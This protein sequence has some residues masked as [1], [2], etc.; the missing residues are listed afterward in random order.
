MS[1]KLRFSFFTTA[2]LVSSSCLAL[3]PSKIANAEILSPKSSWSFSETD[4]MCSISSDYFE[5]DIALKFIGYDGFIENFQVSLPNS[6]ALK[7]ISSYD[8]K[9]VPGYPKKSLEGSIIA[10]QVVFNVKNDEQ[11]SK[12]LKLSG[13]LY[14]TA[15]EE[16]YTLSLSGIR[17]GMNK[18]NTC[19][20][21]VNVALSDN[22]AKKVSTLP[23]ANDEIEFFPLK[24]KS[25]GKA[26][27]EK[28]VSIMVLKEAMKQPQEI[29][30]I[31]KPKAEKPIAVESVDEKTARGKVEVIDVAETPVEEVVEKVEVDEVALNDEVSKPVSLLSGK[32]KKIEQDPALKGNMGSVQTKIEVSKPKVFV[33]KES[34]VNENMYSELNEA[35]KIAARRIENLNQEI[36]EQ[37]LDAQKKLDQKRIELDNLK[38]KVN[39]VKLQENE[40]ETEFQKYKQKVEAETAQEIE[41]LERKLEEQKK[42]A[43]D[44]IFEKEKELSDLEKKSEDM[45]L[46]ETRNQKELTKYREYIEKDT[47]QKIAVLERKLEEQNQTAKKAISMKEHELSSLQKKSESLRLA[48]TKKQAELN[49]YKKYVE[50]DLAKKIEILERKIE[51]Q[52]QRAQMSKQQEFET[53][54][55]QMEKDSAIKVAELEKQ[56]MQKTKDAELN[57]ARKEFELEQLQKQAQAYQTSEQAKENQIAALKT[58]LS[59]TLVEQNI[60]IENLENKA[61]N[62]FENEIA[63]LQHAQIKLHRGLKAKSQEIGVLKKIITEQSQRDNEKLSRIEQQVLD[64]SS[65]AHTIKRKLEQERKQKLQMEVQKVKVKS[66]NAL[67]R[68]S[69]ETSRKNSSSEHIR[70]SSTSPKMIDLKEQSSKWNAYKGSSLREVIAMWSIDDDVEL[71]WDNDYQFE[72]L[73]N[74]TLGVN[75]FEEAVGKILDQYVAYP[76]RPL[77]QLYVDPETGRRILVVTTNKA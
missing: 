36:L 57:L 47:A 42:V 1:S 41:A 72:I 18:M 17:Q 46:A 7:E 31:S 8:V 45:R 26:N 75:S 22:D 55:L 5:K 63:M 66:E 29:K 37:K 56:L 73:E 61:K 69:E 76:I 40:K 51:E 24:G 9:I 38:N 48:E 30:I 62:E 28:P 34:G 2:L 49:E 65:E 14:V 58:E 33:P 20:A 25:N 74:V 35:N 10:G 53:L 15:G 19:K 32:Q 23:D 43:Q 21:M 39:E 27:E 16:T 13:V 52:S 4:N 3:I 71:I 59:K 44:A 67:K 64:V 68:K 54:R 50:Q 11:F 70:V 77:G 60:K 12:A 6:A